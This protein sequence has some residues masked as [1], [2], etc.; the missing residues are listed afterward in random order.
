MRAPVPACPSR[1]SVVLG[2]PAL[3]TAAA[4]S[5]LGG[6]AALEGVAPGSP[7]RAL[8]AIDSLPSQVRPT[9]P[10]A[11]VT[12]SMV[13]AD[14]ASSLGSRLLRQRL[15]ASPGSN[16]LVC[17]AGLSLSLAML[18]AQAPSLGQGVADLLGAGSDDDA[19]AR[20]TMWRRAQLALQRFDTLSVRELQHFDP[21]RLPEQPLLHLASNLLLVGSAKDT[22]NQSYVDAVRTWYDAAVSY[23]AL[24]RAAE[25]ANAWTSLHTGGLVRRSGLQLDGSTRLVLQNAVLLAARWTLPFRPTDTL[26]DQVFHLP[27]QGRSRADLMVATAHL[28]LV[29]DTQWRALRLPYGPVAKEGSGKG[30][31]LDVVLPRKTV[32][33]TE[34][35]TQAWSQATAALTELERKGRS[36]PEVRVRLPRLDLTTEATDLLQELS[37]LDVELGSLEHIGP[38]LVVNQTVQQARLVVDEEGTVAAALTEVQVGVSAPLPA[39]DPVEFFVDHPFVARIVDAATGMPVF[40]AVVVDPASRSAL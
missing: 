35:G 8:R 10:P 12:T 5:G 14:A 1:R 21:D 22:V 11:D 36:G 25:A 6:C 30:L 40:E 3:A 19:T 39:A 34:L 24:D 33:P 26:Q 27:G 16:A 17:P 23:V 15:E 4:L 28:P 2:V 31:V 20:D 32:H 9:S 18:Y 13:A 38:E 7:T 37:S 29:E